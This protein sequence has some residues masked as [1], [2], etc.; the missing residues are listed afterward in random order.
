MVGGCDRK[1]CSVCTY[2]Q[3]VAL[4]PY[5]HTDT[6]THRHTDTQTRRHTDTQTHRHTDTQTHRHADTQT[7]VTL[8]PK[9]HTHTKRISLQ[10]KSLLFS[11]IRG[12]L[13]LTTFCYAG[14]LIFI[15]IWF[16]QQKWLRIYN[17]PVCIASSILPTAL[18]IN[19]FT[20]AF[21]HARACT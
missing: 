17:I 7:H 12:F 21:P 3:I 18:D 1:H 2:S 14:R 20:T 10:Q 5:R 4:P 19:C 15:F 13:L 8:L 16:L 11:H 6:Q 9:T